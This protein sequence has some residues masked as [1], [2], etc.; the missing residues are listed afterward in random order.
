MG[1]KIPAAFE[2]STG[3]IQRLTGE[4]ELLVAATPGEVL[5][6]NNPASTAGFAAGG[7][8]V[9]VSA[10]Y[11]GNAVTAPNGMATGLTFDSLDVGTDL[12]DRTDPANP[13]F[14][15][16]GTYAV[17]VE[18]ASTAPLTA[19]GYALLQFEIL[20]TDGVSIRSYS[21][22]PDLGF[23]ASITGIAATGTLLTVFVRN[24]DGASSRDFLLEQ[25]LVVKLA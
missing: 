15:A 5:T 9:P 22:A 12:L 21:A 14:L 6:A 2:D 13:T 23:G 11:S 16:A 4:I 7:G 19:A 3:T 18:I 17:T 8:S 10:S 20:G 1:V 24:F 25:C